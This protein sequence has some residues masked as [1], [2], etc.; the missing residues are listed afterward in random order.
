MNKLF[1]TSKPMVWLL[2]PL[3]ATAVSLGVEL[4]VDHEP[5][6]S[7][8]LAD[9]LSMA[10]PETMGL[11]NSANRVEIDLSGLLRRGSTWHL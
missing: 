6:L 11:F 7:N 1:T 3:V 10:K 2:Q 5:S 9:G 4:S 8:G